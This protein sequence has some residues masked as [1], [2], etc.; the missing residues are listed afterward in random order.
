MAKIEIILPPMGEGI[1]EAEITRWLVSEGDWVRADEPVVEVA[2]DKVDS[3]I[4]SPAE[5]IIQKILLAEGDTPKIGQVLAI[6]TTEVEEPYP[7]AGPTEKISDREEKQTA[8]ER[9]EPVKVKPPPPDIRNNHPPGNRIKPPSDTVIKT[10]ELQGT[11]IA[12]LTP[13]VRQMIRREN[14]SPAEL[15]SIKG[16]GLEG[17][18]TKKDITGYLKEREKSIPPGSSPSQTVEDKEKTSPPQAENFI[19]KETLYSDTDN[20][21]IEMDR[22]RRIIADHMVYSVRTSPHVTSFVEVDVTNLVIWR[23]KN[24]EAFLKKYNQKITYTPL[25]IEA[26]ARALKD[27]P[28]INISLDGYKII[29]KGKINIGMAVNLP[30]GALVVPVIRDADKKNLPGLVAV[31]NDLADRARENTLKPAEIQG[32]T[33]TVTNIGQFENLTGTPIINQPEVA[34]LAAGV[35]RKKPAVIETADGDTIG[36]RHIMILSLTYDHRAI[37]G[38]LGGMFLKKIGEYLELADLNRDFNR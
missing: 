35:I 1:I 34:I 3:E 11:T 23:E 38:A 31:V 32:G 8:G 7:F 5:G 19:S 14:I 17:R 22:T 4:P 18:I 28:M 10:S 33:F 12:F 37:D 24:K 6:I 20:E 30:S 21:I 13:F 16:S 36:I 2:T 25:I 15:A 9:I 29:R 26:S 27:F